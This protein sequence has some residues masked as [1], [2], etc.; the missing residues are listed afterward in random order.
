[1][2]HLLI[3]GSTGIAETTAALA[4][5]KGHRVFTTG[6]DENADHR[7]DLRQE[8]GVD[9]ALQAAIAT[10][11]RIDALFHVAGISGRRYGDAPLHEC[12][13]D[14]F[15]VRAM[16]Q[17]IDD[18]TPTEFP[19]AVVGLMKALW[20]PMVESLVI[21]WQGKEQDDARV[22]AGV[23]KRCYQD[24]TTVSLFGSSKTTRNWAHPAV[25][26][27]GS[28][29]SQ[30][31]DSTFSMVLLEFGLDGAKSEIGI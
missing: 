11:G 14:G 17:K 22:P 29:R 2:L 25:P 13:L 8:E 15:E 20:K 10:M 9:A 16:K 26:M 12:T 28:V 18:N 1:M 6:L 30:S 27:S 3:T 19:A 24:Y 23:F 5:A 4:R 7:A 21:D 31:T